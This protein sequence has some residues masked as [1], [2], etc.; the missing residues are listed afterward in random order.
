M[1]SISAVV[2]L[3]AYIACM[4]TAI[5][6]A[7]LRTE[8]TAQVRDAE[9]RV[10]SLETRYYDAIARIQSTDM[11]SRGFVTPQSVGYAKN[12]ILTLTRADR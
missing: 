5:F 11:L 10:G 2:L 3:V 8:L 12:G 4:A 6:F 9:I 7:T 1:L